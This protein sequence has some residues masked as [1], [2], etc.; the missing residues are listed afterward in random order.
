MASAEL[1]IGNSVAVGWGFRQ[2][3]HRWDG[4]MALHRQLTMAQDRSPLKGMR[5]H[6]TCSFL[7]VVWLDDQT[8][9]IAPIV[10]QSQNN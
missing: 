2:I 1:G 6:S 10:L 5:T 4:G 9:A 3:C 7:G 8:V